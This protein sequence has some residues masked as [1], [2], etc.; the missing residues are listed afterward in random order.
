MQNNIFNICDIVTL[1]THP[2]KDKFRIKG[3]VK[4]VPPI[5]LVK[6]VH[7]E[8]MNKRIHN[9]ELGEK[10]ADNIKY[11]CV[12]FNDNKMEF[13]ELFVYHSMLI[14]FD[15]LKYERITD[16]RK[17]IDQSQTLIDEV[18][19]YALP[20]YKFG[21]IIYLKT[22]KLEIY[23]KKSSKKITLEDDKN[24]KTESKRV[25]EIKESLQYLVCY[26][27]PDFIISGLKKNENKNLFFK[28][29]KARII[30]SEL[31]VKVLWFN[32]FQ[33]KNSEQYLPLGFFTDLNPFENITKVVIPSP[34][35]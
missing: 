30:V 29:G 22:K 12:Y 8:D 34:L 9:E 32:P 1:K 3:D 35:P 27:S 7:V 33:Q 23:K 20:T 4:I 24:S 25:F 18:K 13:N 2:L 15:E 19:G 21:K 5:M 26:S 6:E 10:I 16:D 14:S 28:D 31:L 11:L 17:V